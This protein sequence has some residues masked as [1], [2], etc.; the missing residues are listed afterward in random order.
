MASNFDKLLKLLGGLLR[1]EVRSSIHLSYRRVMV[2]IRPPRL[3]V[4]PIPA[5]V[6]AA[7]RTAYDAP[8]RV[9]EISPQCNVPN[10]NQRDESLAWV[11]FSNKRHS[12]AELQND[13]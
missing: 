12:V 1:L 8:A 6:L 9:S 11:R 3:F 13:A 4:K 10:S 5:S 7:R 2:T